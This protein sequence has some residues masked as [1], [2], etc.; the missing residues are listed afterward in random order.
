ME[1]R[2]LNYFLTAANEES[3]TKAAQLLHIT[4]PTLSRQLMQ[5]EQE[6]GVKLF[7]R[8][9][10]SIS[11]TNEGMLLKR[12]AKEIVSLAEKT[13]KEFRQSEENLSG[14]ISVGCGELQSMSELSCRIAEF[15]KMHPMVSFDIYTATADDVRL[16]M[17]NGMVDLGLLLEPSDTS[18]Y[19][20]IRMTTKEQWGAMVCDTCPLSKKEYLTAADIVKYPIM[21]PSRDS[22]KKELMNWFGDAAEKLNISA[23]FN[24]SYNGAVFAQ[25]GAAIALSLKLDCKYDGLTF[26]PLCPAVEFGSVL[27]WKAHQT[28]PP[29]A[30]AFIRYV[31]SCSKGIS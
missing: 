16:R 21:L 7:E 1:L 27:A 12:R 8:S 6:L 3:I 31:K 28:F 24:L 4:Q 2:V 10:H 23:T 19:E 18:K 14:V 13:Q 26:V 11:L 22:I 20:F 29:A 9:S 25:R 15:Q 5:L 30:A 17:E